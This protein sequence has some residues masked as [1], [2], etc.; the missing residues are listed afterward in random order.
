[1]EQKA[2]FDNEKKA[3]GV[4]EVPFRIPK[5]VESKRMQRHTEVYVGV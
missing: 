4:S 2:S 3:E 5:S 1:V